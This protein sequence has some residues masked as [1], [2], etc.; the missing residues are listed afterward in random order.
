[1]DRA[2]LV[3][4]KTQLHT[5]YKPIWCTILYKLVNAIWYWNNYQS[6]Q[7]S[8]KLKSYG[9]VEYINLGFDDS[10]SVHCKINDQIWKSTYRFETYC[11]IKDITDD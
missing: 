2:Y 9:G 1:M 8:L 10:T 6:Y 5:K 4:V 3:C 7:N 11:D